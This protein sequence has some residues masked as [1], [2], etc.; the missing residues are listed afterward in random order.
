MPLTLQPQE[1]PLDHPAS[2]CMFQPGPDKPF[3]ATPAAIAKFRNLILVCL[4]TP[5]AKA[6]DNNGLDRLQVFLDSETDE[7]LWV[8]EDVEAITALLLEYY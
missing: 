8:I 7:K 3:V 4:M 5:Q 1:I 2:N 6:K